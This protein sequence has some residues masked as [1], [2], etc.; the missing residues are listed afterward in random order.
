MNEDMLLLVI[1]CHL[2]EAVGVPQSQIHLT[3]NLIEELGVDDEC[4]DFFLIDLQ[5]AVTLPD[6]SG[7]VLRECPTVEAVIE[8][9]I[10]LIVS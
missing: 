2:S 5:D 8:A 3:T 7:L 6:L 9:I 4:F 1:K 10:G